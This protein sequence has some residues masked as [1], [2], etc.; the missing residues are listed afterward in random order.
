MR[1]SG[2]LLR[3][4]TEEIDVLEARLE[5]AKRHLHGDSSGSARRVLRI[6]EGAEPTAPRSATHIAA[7]ES[8]N[9]LLEKWGSDAS[10]L[11]GEKEELEQQ[12]ATA[13][14]ERDEWAEAIRSVAFGAVSSPKAAHAT[15][16][17]LF[18]KW[19]AESAELEKLR[20]ERDS[21][22][23]DY[24]IEGDESVLDIVRRVTGA[25]V[26]FS[27][28]V[29][30][31]RARVSE[32]ELDTKLGTARE[33]LR[34]IKFADDEIRE[35]TAELEK[36]R[37]ERDVLVKRYTLCSDE[38]NN[39]AFDL[40]RL[41]A[42]LATMAKAL[43]APG[44]MELEQLP[45]LAAETIEQLRQLAD[46]KAADIAVSLKKE[47]D[48]LRARLTTAQAAIKEASDARAWL[49]EVVNSLTI[50]GVG[51]YSLGRKDMANALLNKW[52]VAALAAHDREE[53]AAPNV[54][55]AEDHGRFVVCGY[56]DEPT[57][58]SV[59]GLVLARRPDVDQEVRRLIAR[60]TA[61]LGDGRRTTLWV[62]GEMRLRE[63]SET[64][65]SRRIAAAEAV[66][67]ALKSEHRHRVGCI[68]K[69]CRALTAYR[70]AK[71]DCECAAYDATK[72]S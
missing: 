70:L 40:H 34:Q 12:L 2:R 47:N 13:L 71:A 57:S 23:R 44:E 67:E 33:T 28:E 26:A 7:A 42:L 3:M 32:M 16:Q 21:L 15:I 24:Q 36:L 25:A 51:D 30:K 6:L 37:A 54:L 46:T 52:P 5:E 41:R 49:V 56:P 50:S 66:C 68:C 63:Q 53:F 64:S 65:V 10:R 20:A 45:A 39:Y 8:T 72:E 69:L 18:Q 9:K 55:R 11:Q 61:W 48:S 62:R 31:L 1:A 38:R 19:Q 60:L 17:E 14:A 59:I 58:G 35:L 27:A 22:M 4:L 43:R 29:E